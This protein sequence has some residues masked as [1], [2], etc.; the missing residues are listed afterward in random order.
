M[1]NTHN[2]LDDNPDTYTYV[3]RMVSPISDDPCNPDS[4]RCWEA[5]P[6]GTV[7]SVPAFPGR[8]ANSDEETY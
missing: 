7:K 4:I 6:E 5:M 2:E 8:D 1:N 3:P